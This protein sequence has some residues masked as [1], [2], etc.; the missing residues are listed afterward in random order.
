LV[1]NHDLAVIGRLDVTAFNPW[2]RAAADWTSTQLRAADVAWLGSLPSRTVIGGMTL[3]HASPRDPV[4]EYVTDEAT[5]AANF[6]SFDTQVCWI[7]HSHVA[8]VASRDERGRTALRALGDGETIDLEHARWLINPG[9]VGQPRDGDPRAAYVILDL[10]QGRAASHRV[11]Y[12]IARTQQQMSDAGLPP[13]LIERLRH[14][15]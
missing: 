4:W 2:A 3:A 6:T 1:G 14:G 15:I 11:P 13:P 8:L 9:S 12:D 10:D 7:G 5:A